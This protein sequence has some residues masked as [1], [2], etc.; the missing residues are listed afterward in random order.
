VLKRRPWRFSLR[1][2]QTESM[3]LVELV[4]LDRRPR[5]VAAMI[6]SGEGI[7]WWSNRSDGRT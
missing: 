4:L 6:S 7:M 3:L 1:V 2:L 5:V